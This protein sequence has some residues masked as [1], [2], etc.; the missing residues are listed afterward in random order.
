MDLELGGRVALIPGGTRGIGL[1]TAE[2]FAAAGA[3]VAICGRDE[4][5]LRSAVA[6][7][8]ARGVEV[9]AQRADVTEPAE[10]AGFVDACVDRFGRIDCLVNNVGGSSGGDLLEASDDDWLHTFERNLF[11]AVRAI[12]MVVPTMTDGGGGAIV[13]IASISGWRPQL[14]G[15]LQYGAAKAALIYLTE[16]LALRL[17][18]Q[19][20]RVNTVSPGSITWSAGGWDRF[21]ASHPEVYAAYVEEGFPAGRLGRPEEVADVI[22]FLASERGTWINGQHIGVD[23]GQQPVPAR[24]RALWAPRAAG[25]NGAEE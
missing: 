4:A 21:A 12:R 20:I 11:H 1:R 25:A 8:E 6:S 23:G 2:A 24:D 3:A 18:R 17:A 14:S 5:S 16:P 15:T 22:V 9:L 7:L 13:N 10:L 19:S